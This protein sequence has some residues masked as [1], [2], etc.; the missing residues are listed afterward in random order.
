MVEEREVHIRLQDIEGNVEDEEL[1]GS[2]ST[3]EI[4]YFGEVRTLNGFT[5]SQALYTELI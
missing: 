1:A 5:I 4:S 2:M 3:L